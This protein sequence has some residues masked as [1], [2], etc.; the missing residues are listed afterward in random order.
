MND[1]IDP[2]ETAPIYDGNSSGEP[3]LIPQQTTDCS[4]ASDE[5]QL[6]GHRA[7]MARDEPGPEED[8]SKPSLGRLAV[9]GAVLLAA[10]ILIGFAIHS[11]SKPPP[12][13]IATDLGTERS[14]SAGIG[15]RLIVQWKDSASYRLIVD[16]LEPAD[17]P[18][19]EDFAGNLPH[20]IVFA[21]TLKDSSGGVACQ[22]QIVLT[23]S[24]APG[25]SGQARNPSA[26][27]TATGDAAQ[28]VTNKDGK[29][30]ELI[31]SGALP[32]QLEAFQRLAAWE[33]STD[34]PP[35][36]GQKAL[37][38]QQNTSPKPKSGSLPKGGGHRQFAT[39]KSFPAPIE[40]D[41]AV[42]SDNPS[43]NLI[44]TSG[45]RTFVLGTDLRKGTFSW[46]SFPGRIHYRCEKNG[47]CFLTN[48]ESGAAVSARLLQ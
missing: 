3:V 8:L 2:R 10:I 23:S 12:T 20:A 17:L 13:V 38:N 42:V 32:C 44:S 47:T 7:A 35:L 33:F 24:T 14:G 28:G 18:A 34:F 39:V 5:D 43:K 6:Y 30:A 37:F 11:R 4:A 19:F 31:L 45:G 9:L 16:P 22:K 41:D 40:G 1:A 26:L 48:T 15:G 46:R 25:S 21:I 29:I 36:S 27:A